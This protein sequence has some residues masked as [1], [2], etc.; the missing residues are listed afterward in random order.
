MVTAGSGTTRVRCPTAGCDARRVPYTLVSFHAHPDDEVLLTG[1]TLARAAAEGHRVVLVVATDGA[2]GL[3][4]SSLRDDGQLAGRRLAELERSAAALG[5]ARVVV[6]GF[7]DSGWGDSAAAVAPEAFSRIPVADAVAPLAA[8]L[9]EERADVLTVYDPAGGYGHP[10]HRRV[11]EVGVLAARSAR[12]PVVLEATIDRRLI[13]R[14]VRLVAAVPGVL[15]EVRVRDF[16]SSYSAHEAIT[17]RVDV[18]RY[19]PAKRRAMAAHASQATSDEGTRTISL[20]LRLPPWLF[21]WVMGREW[22]VERDRAPDGQLDDVFA[23]L[24]SQER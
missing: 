1:G 24:R 11:H 20:L 8:L 23:S 19:A 21:A 13:R 4:A 22:F 7:T 17:H 6:L 5:C 16:A 12:T 2:A 3:A 9:R 18:R 14:L 15:P 10:D